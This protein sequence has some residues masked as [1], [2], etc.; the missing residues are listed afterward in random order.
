VIITIITRLAGEHD[1]EQ[2]QVRSQ[3]PRQSESVGAAG[4]LAYPEAIAGEVVGKGAHD[5]FVVL[6]YQDLRRTGYQSMLLLLFRS[7]QA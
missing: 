7:K 6:D 4:R 5:H 2:D 3:L 1:V